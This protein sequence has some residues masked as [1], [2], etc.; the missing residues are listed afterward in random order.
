VEDRERY[1]LIHGPDEMLAEP[2]LP[3]IVV[4]ADAEE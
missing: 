2:E 4:R 1:K 3:F